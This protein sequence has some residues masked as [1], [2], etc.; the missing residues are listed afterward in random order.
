M[1]RLVVVDLDIDNIS[2][3]QTLKYNFTKHLKDLKKNKKKTQQ[4]L[5]YAQSPARHSGMSPFSNFELQNK[6]I[7]R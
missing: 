4:V 1:L 3:S 2:E 5:K 7:T 6:Q